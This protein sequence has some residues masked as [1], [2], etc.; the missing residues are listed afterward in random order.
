MKVCFPFESSGKTRIQVQGGVS[1]RGE[2]KIE[3]DGQT[4]ATATREELQL[5]RK[6]TVPDGSILKVNLV[7]RGLK[8]EVNAW[9]NEVQ[10]PRNAE[11]S[12]QRAQ[13]VLFFVAVANLLFAIISVVSENGFDLSSSLALL[14][15]LLFLGLGW[16]FKSRRDL[17]LLPAL[18][19]LLI[20]IIAAVGILIFDFMNVLQQGWALYRLVAIVLVQT[21]F[22][23]ALTSAVGAS[24][25]LR[26][27]RSV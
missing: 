6:F 19:L 24:S 26:R 16:L 10:L 18:L 4:I 27:L 25:G 21:S 15:G 5:G 12:I 9:R 23:F 22:L 14:W 7:S 3:L 11:Q 17:V 20:N 2:W 1:G 8:D 13:R